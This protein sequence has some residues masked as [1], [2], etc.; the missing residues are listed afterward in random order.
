VH[1]QTGAFAVSSA[2][3]GVFS[4]IAGGGFLPHLPFFYDIPKDTFQQMHSSPEIRKTLFAVIAL[5]TTL[6]AYSQLPFSFSRNYLKEKND[7]VKVEPQRETDP[8][9]ILSV[10]TAFHEDPLSDSKRDVFRII[11]FGKPGDL[12]AIVIQKIERIDSTCVVTIKLLKNRKNLMFVHSKTYDISKWN[13]FEDLAKKYFRPDSK[14][15]NV[16]TFNPHRAYQKYEYRHSG[17][18][19]TMSG[20]DA[21]S[22]IMWLRDY[23]E[24]LLSPIFEVTCPEG[25]ASE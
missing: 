25:K 15:T 5:V 13:D 18:Y 1:A 2:V 6:P 20:D 10:I 22:N 8:A 19:E 14:F 11:D 21:G 24:Y 17:N 23:L 3:L 7:C 12:K 16:K 4:D 9:D